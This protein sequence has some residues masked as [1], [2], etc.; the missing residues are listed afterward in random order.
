MTLQSTRGKRFSQYAY[1]VGEVG[2]SGRG[3]LAF[4]TLYHK[5]EINNFS[6]MYAVTPTVKKNCYLQDM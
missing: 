6:V 3:G 1:N 2:G 4:L 5:A